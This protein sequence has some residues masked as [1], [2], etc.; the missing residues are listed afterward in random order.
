MFPEVPILGGIDQLLQQ[1]FGQPQ[2][3][4]GYTK[5]FVSPDGGPGGDKFITNPPSP[6][7]SSQSQSQSETVIQPGALLQPYQP[8]IPNPPGIPWWVFV[9]AA[10]V[11]AYVVDPMNKKG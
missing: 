11:T 8:T 2:S 4:G 10:A 7:A 3:G 6:S 9:I 5:P 1:L